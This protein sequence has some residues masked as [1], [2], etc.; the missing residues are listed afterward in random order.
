M[1]IQIAD[2]G[3][4]LARLVADRYVRS[5]PRVPRH[6]RPAQCLGSAA[7]RRCGALVDAEIAKSL[8]PGTFE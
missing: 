5:P 6:Q 7:L 1:D 8:R 3:A 2:S 4:A